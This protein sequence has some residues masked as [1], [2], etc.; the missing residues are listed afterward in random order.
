MKAIPA[1]RKE[2]PRLGPGPL[3]AASTGGGGNDAADSASTRQWSM[4]PAQ[5]AIAVAG[6]G[7]SCPRA[8]AA[9]ASA[10]PSASYAHRRIAKGSRQPRRAQSRIASARSSQMGSLRGVPAR[11]GLEPSSAKKRGRCVAGSKRPRRPKPP[12]AMNAGHVQ[13]Q[14][15][16]PTI[17]QGN[18]SAGAGSRSSQVGPGC[19]QDG[20]R[21]R[22]RCAR[23]LCRGYPVRS[24]T[25]KG[26]S[27]RP[28]KGDQAEEPAGSRWRLGL[29]P[30]VRRSGSRMTLR[31]A[32]RR[33]MLKRCV[34]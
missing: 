23:G 30:S 5:L 31:S 2:K 28:H 12:G 1:P 8:E 25:H 15:P 20:P 9:G 33:R 3:P 32:P 4:V 27:A 22:E 16:T 18:V 26:H 13:A 24:P 7:S 14:S 21:H 11:G 17:R 29:H 10:I 6:L 19:K 34:S